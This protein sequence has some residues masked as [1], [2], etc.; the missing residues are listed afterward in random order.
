MLLIKEIIV[1]LL[2]LTIFLFVSTKS[3]AFNFDKCSKVMGRLGPWGFLTTSGQFTT[4][5]GD[6]AMLGQLEN[7]KKNFI[8]Q[9]FEILKQDFAK[10]Q[11]EYLFTYANLSGFSGNDGNIFS[12]K[13]K[14]N[15]TRVFGENLKLAP[16]QSYKQ[17]ELLIKTDPEL[18]NICKT[19]A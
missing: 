6:C 8:A 13:I 19:K 9:N 15:Y 4:S 18:K 11:G 1:K 5:T 17:I 14:K 7:N 2:F 3:F 12:Q 10:G 16:E